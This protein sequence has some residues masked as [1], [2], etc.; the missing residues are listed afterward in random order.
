MHCGVDVA[1]RPA[2]GGSALGV[3]CDGSRFDRAVDRVQWDVFR[4]RI[5]AAQGWPLLRLTSPQVFRDPAAAIGAIAKA[6]Q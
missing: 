2:A 1:V 4:S 3:L 5:L 6:T